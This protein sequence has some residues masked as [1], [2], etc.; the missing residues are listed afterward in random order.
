MFLEKKAER[1]S[2]LRYFWL[3]RKILFA[4]LLGKQWVKVYLNFMMMKMLIR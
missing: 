4:L 2:L 1:K 3:F